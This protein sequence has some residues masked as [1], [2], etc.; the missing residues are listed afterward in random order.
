MTKP[1]QV[2]G[3]LTLLATLAT[4][5]AE[6][7]MSPGLTPRDDRVRHDAA[8]PRDEGEPAYDLW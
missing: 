2:M 6:A 7:A 8:V 4:G 5:G 3:T 1:K